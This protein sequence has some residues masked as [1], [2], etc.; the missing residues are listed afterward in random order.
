MDLLQNLKQQTILLKKNMNIFF[1]NLKTHPSSQDIIQPSLECLHTTISESSDYPVKSYLLLQE[2]R[3]SLQDSI[4]DTK[5]TCFSKL[6]SLISHHNSLD[7]AIESAQ[8]EI[9]KSEKTRTH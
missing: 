7:H 9:D 3:N 5:A 1:N 4:A 8:K 6:K 2:Q